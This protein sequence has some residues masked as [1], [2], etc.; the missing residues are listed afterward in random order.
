MASTSITFD[1]T[2]ATVAGAGNSAGGTGGAL[3]AG[4]G[5]LAAGAHV[6]ILHLATLLPAP[7]DDVA[8]VI[9]RVPLVDQRT[10]AEEFFAFLVAPSPA[11]SR[12]NEGRTCYMV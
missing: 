9:Q 12:L 6:P 5:A 3:P 8:K 11:L 7:T 1:A 2:I 4:T 10:Q